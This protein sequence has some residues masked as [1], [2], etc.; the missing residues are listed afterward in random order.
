MFDGF[1][2]PG[3]VIGAALAAVPLLIHLLNRQRFK[4]LSWAAMRFVEAAYRKTRRRARLENLLLLLLRMGAIALLAL[5]VARPF[6]GARSKLAGLTESRRDIALILDASYSTGW[7]DGVRTVFEREVESARALLASLDGARGDRARLVVAARVPRLLSWRTPEEAL[8][9]LDTLGAPTDEPLDLALALGEVRGYAE[10]LGRGEGV[11]SLEVHLLTDLQRATFSPDLRSGNGPTSVQRPQGAAAAVDP[12]VP[13]GEGPPR[14]FEELDRLK[15]LGLRVWVHD[16]GPDQPFPANLA[17]SELAPQ[18]R[19]LGPDQPVDIGLRIDNSGAT[20]VSGVR[21]ALEI[22]GERRP[23]RLLDVPGRGFARL[24]VAENFRERGPHRVRAMLE[25]DALAADDTRA[26]VVVV[27]PAV[28]VLLVNGA[29]ST[30]LARDEV[31][32]LAAALEPAR[33]DDAGLLQAS[34]FEVR[35]VDPARL[36]EADLDLGSFDVIWLANV[37]NLLPHAVERLEARI[38]SGASLV[39][40]LGDRADP[41][42]YAVRLFKAD[43]TG[44]L[45]A[46]LI[47]RSLVARDE[48][49]WRI[50]DFE[51]THPALLFFAD[52]RWKP[53]LTEIP[54]YGFFETR[55]LDDARVLARFDDAARSPALI[56]RNFDR[57]RVFLWTS[58]IDAD[59]TRLP[60]SP[61]TLVPFLHELVRHAGA[62]SDSDP[63]L[64]VGGSYAA[65]VEVFPRKLALLSPDGTRRAIVGDADPVGPGAWMLP[66]VS[67]TERAGLYE[68][69]ME[70][71]ANLPFAVTL[72]TLESDLARLNLA[73]LGALHPA[74]QAWGA[75]DGPRRNDD[76]RGEQK[77]ELWRLIAAAALACIVL[78]TLWAAWIGRSRSVR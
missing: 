68:I 24:V 70:G 57:G 31:G 25:S 26:A 19:V 11:Q 49:Y 27:P 18:T 21:V 28:R 41:I 7:R 9:L 64:G 71:R 6:V 74:L 38:A 5:A 67:T 66:A 30:D 36:A 40:S 72:D 14:L 47:T 77:G 42:A 69:E 1:V 39:V 54:F 16:L 55:P 13:V 12:G 51:V 60:E 76:S 8:D 17:I 29:P 52:E 44:L 53:L 4:P 65:R 50:Q 59:W 34:P 61:R 78:E 23:Q 46:E 32:Y 2:H 58:T 48:R 22:D 33:A 20:S 73:E 10:E 3:L 15:E 37:E 43:G 45:P 56:E 75:A 63:N 35:T 62:S